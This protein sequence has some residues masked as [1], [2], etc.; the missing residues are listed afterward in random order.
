MQAKTFRQDWG[1]EPFFHIK[2]HFYDPDRPDDHLWPLGCDETNI[3]HADVE[4]YLTI[5]L[6][7]TSISVDR[8][9]AETR[10]LTS[11]NLKKTVRAQALQQNGKV[12]LKRA[13]NALRLDPLPN[14]SEKLNVANGMG[15]D[16]SNNEDLLTVS[17]PTIE[18]KLM[19]FGM[20]TLDH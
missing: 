10:R 8:M 14:K 12:E 1:V 2:K 15:K 7:C 11:L 18:P 20:G 5:P 17:E 16:G 6:L 19:L 13:L 3:H 4:A 9:L